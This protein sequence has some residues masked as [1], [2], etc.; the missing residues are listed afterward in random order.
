[1][2]PINNERGDIRLEIEPELS[3]DE[4]I[5]IL[6]RSTLAQRRPVDDVSVIAGMLSHADVIAT[7]R[8]RHG[9]LVGVSRALTD[10]HYCTYLSDLAVDVAFQRMGIGRRLIEFSHDR[11]GR[12]TTLILLAAPAAVSYYEH[13]G[14]SPHPSCWVAKPS[15]PTA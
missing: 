7:A 14:M 13:I 1:M 15:C 8:N 11:A 10:F 6:R 5:D 4:F 3:T 2:T 12:D 9:R